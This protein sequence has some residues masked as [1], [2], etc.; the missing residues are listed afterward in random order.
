M[1]KKKCTGCAASQS[2]ARRRAMMNA[3]DPI[4]NPV[5]VDPRTRV[6]QSPPSYNNAHYTANAVAQSNTFNRDMAKAY[7]R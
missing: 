7:G 2:D 3:Y 1:G 6:M 5:R 4:P